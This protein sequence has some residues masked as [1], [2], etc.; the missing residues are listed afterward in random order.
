[1]ES[2]Q[3]LA[4]ANLSIANAIATIIAGYNTN[5]SKIYSILSLLSQENKW[6][7]ETKVGIKYC[8]FY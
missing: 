3:L 1:M 5:L 8:R 2:M 7:I 4:L 6:G